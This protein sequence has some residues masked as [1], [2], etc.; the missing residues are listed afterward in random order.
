MKTQTLVSFFLLFSL[1]VTAQ[2]E[3]QNPL[4]KE[5]PFQLTLMTP[6]ISTNGM[7]FDQCVN[8]LS[9][10]TFLGVSAGTN[11]FE[12]GGFINMNRYFTRGAQIA[13]F[14]NVCGYQTQPE[15]ELWSQGFQGA[16]FANINRNHF[17]GLCAS[18]FL[19]YNHSLDGV[20]VAGFANYA[21]SV[22][23]AHQLAGFANYVGKGENHI[24]ISG[25]ANKA[26]EISGVQA[27]G[28]INVAKNV[29][30]V[31]VAGFINVCDSI[32]GIPIGF[33]NVVKKNGY[34]SFEVSVTDF[35][36]FQA[37]YKMGV[38]Q[39]YNI[40]TLSMLPGGANN[41]ALGFGF[42]THKNIVNGLKLNLELTS[43]N[44]F[45]L[46]DPALRGVFHTDRLNMVNQLR[47][48]FKKCLGNNMC[49]NVGPTLNVGVS[50]K[51]A[52]EAY[53]PDIE[54]YWNAPMWQ[55]GYTSQS[56]ARIWV[57]FKAGISWH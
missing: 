4:V 19:N 46:F 24:Q 53:A 21:D 56:S 26:E 44:A 38:E 29:K 30:G 10:N 33:I 3:Q 7:D 55:I 48:G 12:M 45:N 31:Q 32:D 22:S 35:S 17:T 41:W 40:Y 2:E 42:G 15:M 47:I 50:S 28:F 1:F 51:R 57:G 37:S 23:N 5:K 54:P 34:R 16:G 43:H 52:G 20:Q 9:L 11:G 49:L 18:G 13:G 14:M 25:F 27:A 6:P 39:F 36:Y 8:R